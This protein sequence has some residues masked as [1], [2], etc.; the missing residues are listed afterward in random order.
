VGPVRDVGLLDAAA[1][2]PRASVFGRDAYPE[3]DLKAAALLEPIVCGHA[4]VDGNKRLGWLAT[5]VFYGLNDIDLEAPDDEAYDVVVAV[6]V[7]RMALDHVALALSRW[8]PPS[9]A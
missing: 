2:P 5:V 8:R 4:L 1:H 6:A 9:M 3:M 7:G